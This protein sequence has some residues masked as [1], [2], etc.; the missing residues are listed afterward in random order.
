MIILQD[1]IDITHLLAKVN[2]LPSFI[3]DASI[4]E[5]DREMC[6]KL[7]VAP[8]GILSKIWQMLIKGLA[9]IQYA[10]VQIDALEMIL[11]RIAYSASLP[12]PADVLKDLKKKIK[13]E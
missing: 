9:E 8:I 2:I 5:N 13:P 4:S 7:C 12:T 6:K 10:G 3:E 1:L 11:M